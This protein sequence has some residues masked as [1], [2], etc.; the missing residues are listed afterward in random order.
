MSKLF[1][2]CTLHDSAIYRAKLDCKV[3]AKQTNKGLTQW[4]HGGPPPSWPLFDYMPLFLSPS[5]PEGK[6]TAFSL[7]QLSILKLLFHQHLLHLD[8]CT[9]SNRASDGKKV[10]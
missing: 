7:F 6:F 4:L 8:I 10:I 1:S 2:L 5:V 9:W 3:T